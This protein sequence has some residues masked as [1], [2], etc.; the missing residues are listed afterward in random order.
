M[1]LRLIANGLV[2]MLL[3]KG[4]HARKVVGV[5]MVEQAVEDARVNATLNGV[6]VYDC[7]YF[8]V[9]VGVCSLWPISRFESPNKGHFGNGNFVPCREGVS[10]SEG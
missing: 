10:F 6:C 9:Q 1:W 4:L 8:C 7:M 3:V 5:E 2:P